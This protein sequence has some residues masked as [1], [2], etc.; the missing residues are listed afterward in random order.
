[1]TLK[2]SRIT[3]Q[4][5]PSRAR[6][7]RSLRARVVLI[8][9]LIAGSALG[10]L[11]IGAAAQE[12]GGE[13]EVRIV[14]RLL[15]SGKIEFGL[16]QRRA[17]TTWGERQLPERRLFPAD[18][19]VDR[20]LWSEELD[21]GFAV[22]RITA[23]KLPDGDVEF[24]LQQ[25]GADDVWGERLLP[26]RRFFPAEATV[27]EWLPSS[28]LD[29][30]TPGGPPVEDPMGLVAG[31]EFATAY[32]LGRDLWEVWLCDTPE[33][34]LFS[35]DRDARLNPDNYADAFTQRVS[36]WFAWQSGGAYE[37]V[38]RGGGLVTAPEAEPAQCEEAVAG[39]IRSNDTDG[40]LIVAAQLDPDTDGI[41]GYA[42]CGLRSRRSWPDSGRSAVVYPGAF[43]HP[44]VVAHELGH[45]LCW[46]HSY[47]GSTLG[48]GVIGE[49]DNVMDQMSGAR[50]DNAA[51]A[52]DVP[53]PLTIGTIAFNRY[54]AG[55][56]DPA[57]VAIHDPGTTADYELAPP[58][59]PGTQMLVLPHPETGTD[60]SFATLGARVRGAGDEEWHDSNIPAEGVEFYWIDQTHEGCRLPDR[61][62]CSGL[63]RRTVPIDTAPYGTGHVVGAGGTFWIIS[64]HEVS[65][66]E[67]SDETGSYPVTVRPIDVLAWHYTPRADP[68]ESEQEDLSGATGEDDEDEEQEN[69]NGATGDADDEAD[70]EEQEGAA[71][72]SAD[73]I[74]G[75]QDFGSKY[76]VVSLNV[77]CSEGLVGV[78]L[79]SWN[80]YIDRDIARGA[81]TARATD[82]TYRFGEESDPQQ[83]RWSVTGGGQGARTPAA[84]IGELI[85]GLLEQEEPLHVTARAVGGTQVGGATFPVATDTGA[86][87]RVLA[88]CGA[89]PA[90]PVPAGD[91]ISLTDESDALE[92]PLPVA[93]LTSFDHDLPVPFHRVP[94]RLFVECVESRP[95]VSLTLGGMTI[96]ERPHGQ[97]RVAHR[98]D[99]DDIVER[100]WEVSSGSRVTMFW[101]EARDFLAGLQDHDRL[102]ARVR[103]PA[104][105]VLGTVTFA[106]L[107]G[108]GEALQPVL[109]TCR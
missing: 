94:A 84:A 51:S 10:P 82:V 7:A 81:A 76:G 103:G 24:G 37:P 8:V 38:F 85:A 11:G 87:K 13:A 46:P 21:L 4:R 14:A 58:G 45:A 77:S 20:W 5:F 55:W 39:A 50:G 15:D 53:F 56:I 36:P 9:L 64:G 101:S 88:D 74:S 102:V 22:V 75:E 18:A 44:T 3:T 68:D 79:Y 52:N 91:W 104:G 65:V 83:A 19:A 25:R 2:V 89:G 106:S 100:S 59:R 95:T 43:G 72:T 67:L 80:D 69:L 16:E 93:V 66:G 12:S 32:S 92:G 61:G 1:M 26:T 29:L 40:V 23:R 33:G 30:G 48:D 57:E 60:G 47:T 70:D 109:D 90:D 17:D 78:V 96:A 98:F 35:T 62:A 54:A 97:V 31:Y 6:N 41:L 86:I 34:E 107:A 73:L 28:S 49:Y 63:D 71:R 105:Q 99:T 27:D 108:A 42:G